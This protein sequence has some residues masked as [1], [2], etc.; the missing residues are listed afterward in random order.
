MQNKNKRRPALHP[1]KI[2]SG[3]PRV[4]NEYN[5]DGIASENRHQPV[6]QLYSTKRLP[7]VKQWDSTCEDDNTRVYA[8]HHSTSPF[9][10][11][12]VAHGIFISFHLQRIVNRR[13]N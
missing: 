9:K 13:N 7:T 1:N 5:K 10:K 12:N 4:L 2:D 3:E 11:I 8:I 6:H